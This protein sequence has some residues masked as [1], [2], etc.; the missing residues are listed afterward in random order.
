LK[1]KTKT[2]KTEEGRVQ[3]EGRERKPSEGLNLERLIPP[4]KLKRQNI[5]KQTLR[6]S[7]IVYSDPDQ[8]ARFAAQKAADDSRALRIEEHFQ[9]GRLAG[10][11]ILITGSNRGIGL[12][13]AKEAVA[14]K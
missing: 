8:P 1:E 7:S 10:Q 11:R 13:L 2:T 14:C 4:S 5:L 9:P 3:L 6:M 12:S